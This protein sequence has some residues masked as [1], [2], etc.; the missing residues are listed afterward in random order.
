MFGQFMKFSNF[1]I[2]NCI[3]V[4]KEKIILN[5]KNKLIDGAL[6]LY[7]CIFDTTSENMKYELYSSPK[8][9]G[10]LNRLD[11]RIRSRAILY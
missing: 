9:D 5:E 10:E 6:L 4:S 1:H 11:H 7:F 2:S 3:T 8:F